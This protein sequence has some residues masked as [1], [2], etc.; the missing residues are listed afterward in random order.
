MKVQLDINIDELRRDLAELMNKH[1]VDA[2]TNT[3]DFML[4]DY[5]VDQLGTWARYHD[6]VR[7]W[8]GV[9]YPLEK[10]GQA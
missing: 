3:P 8:H 5:L 7:K 4:A 2:A 1:H 6:G 10:V 9:K